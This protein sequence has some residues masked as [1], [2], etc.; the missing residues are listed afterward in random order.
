MRKLV[1][2][3]KIDGKVQEREKLLAWFNNYLDNM[4]DSEQTIT[5][6]P[7]GR[8]EAQNRYYWGVVLSTISVNIGES[9]DKLHQLFKEQFL[10]KEEYITF[11]KNIK[12]EST[13]QAETDEF[14]NYMQQIIQW[15][16]ESLN[17]Y[18]PDAEEYKHTR[19]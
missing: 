5:I 19:L 18:I 14:S 13:T 10:P 8:T 7:C 9:R 4:Q 11:I 6:E 12:M 17:I 15:A 1:F 16:A 3:K 2:V